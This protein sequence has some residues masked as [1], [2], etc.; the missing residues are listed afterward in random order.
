MEKELCPIGKC[1]IPCTNDHRLFNH[2]KG[3][4]MKH[5]DRFDYVKKCI[6]DSN[7]KCKDSLLKRLEENE[8]EI[9]VQDEF[10]SANISKKKITL[11]EEPCLNSYL[12]IADPFCREERQYAY[13]LAQ[14]I[15]KGKYRYILSDDV[16]LKIIKVYYEAAFMR[17][18]LYR[19]GKQFNVKFIE[20]LKE[21]IKPQN[22]KRTK[23]QNDIATGIGKESNHANHWDSPHPLAQWMMN[24][25]PD[26]A[27]LCKEGKIY[28][29]YFIEC[30]YESP[31]DNYEKDGFKSGQIETQEMIQRFLCKYLKYKNNKNKAKD[32]VPA[33]VKLVKFVLDT[34][35]QST[36]KKKNMKNKIQEIKISELL[37]NHAPHN[38]PRHQPNR[39]LLR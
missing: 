23:T 20:F 17:D 15:Q 35:K 21:E 39:R 26:I 3:A 29:M 11:T 24:A 33:G 14:K 13:F 6:K 31:V 34:E 30:K 1:S 32:I 10:L 18:Y 36:K 37:D 2:I 22:N 25:K 19:M 16:N 9:T 8:P 28:K 7:L 38:P 5:G 4:H 12:D 27:V